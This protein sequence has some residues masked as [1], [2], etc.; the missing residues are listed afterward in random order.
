LLFLIG[1]CIGAYNI[2]MTITLPSPAAEKT[3]DLPLPRPT[4]GLSPQPAE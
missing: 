3:V 2:W 1:G 4:G